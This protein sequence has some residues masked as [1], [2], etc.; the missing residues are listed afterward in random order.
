MEM[1]AREMTLCKDE[2]FDPAQRKQEINEQLSVKEYQVII[3]LQEKYD[4]FHE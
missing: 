2:K 4:F 3:A 1:E